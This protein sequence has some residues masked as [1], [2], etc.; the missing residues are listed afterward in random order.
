MMLLGI[1]I[2]LKTIFAVTDNYKW[3][4]SGIFKKYS[5]S[6]VFVLMLLEG[7]IQYLAFLFSFDAQHLASASFEQKLVNFVTITVFF[8]IFALGFTLL[9]PLR[10]V[11]TDK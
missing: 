9:I 8:L 11:Y 6:Y 10:V 5:I 4:I 3:R 2:F 1:F 7:N